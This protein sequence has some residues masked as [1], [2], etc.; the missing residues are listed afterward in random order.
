MGRLAPSEYGS[1]MPDPELAA[2]AVD[3]G[4]TS[5]FEPPG[6]LLVWIVLVVETVTFGAGLVTFAVTRRQ[7]PAVFAAGRAA[8]HQP[9]ALFNTLVLLTGGFFMANAVAGLRGGRSSAAARWTLAATGSGVVFLVLKG[10]EW[11]E[12][13]RHGLGLHHDSFFTYYW[14]LTGFHFLHVMVAVAILGFMYLGIRAG[15]YSRED[16]IDV[17]SGGVFWHMCDL[18][19][20]LVYPTIYLLGGGA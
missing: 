13:L 9:L 7:E 4:A 3:P 5:T 17:E 18:I 11:A 10:V 1:E 15:R 8:L 2:P 14:L 12:K 6:G 19:W 20:L 16:H